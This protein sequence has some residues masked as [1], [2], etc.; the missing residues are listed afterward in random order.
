MNLTYK[1][2][3]DLPDIVPAVPSDLQKPRAFSP[4]RTSTWSLLALGLLGLGA[5]FWAK[6]RH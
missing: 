5:M 6:Y 4:K 3:A 2:L 1:S